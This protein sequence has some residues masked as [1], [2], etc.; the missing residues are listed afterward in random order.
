M[1]SRYAF[2]VYTYREICY[3]NTIYLLPNLRVLHSPYPTNIR[4]IAVPIMTT[5]VFQAPLM[6]ILLDIGVPNTLYIRHIDIKRYSLLL[7]GA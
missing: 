4:Q 3:H 5:T 6:I 7:I 1:T 2:S